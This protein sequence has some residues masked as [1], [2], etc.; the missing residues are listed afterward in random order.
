MKVK[1]RRAE[2]EPAL[3]GTLSLDSV[4]VAAES[5]GICGLPDDAI[6]ELAED[7][8]YRLRQVVQD[9]CKFKAHGKRKKLLPIDFDNAL[10]M[11]NME[12]LYGVQS[13]EH[14]PF[15][16]TSGG[17]RELSFQDERDVEL[18]ELVSAQMPKAPL[19]TTIRVHWLCIDGVQPAIPE[20]PPPVALEH[21][22]QESTN[23][24]S[25]IGK[26]PA[27]SPASALPTKS[28]P[29]RAKTIETVSVKQLAQHE[30]S[31][32]LQLYY[33]EITEACVGSDESRRAEAL[34]SLSS[35]PGLHQMLPRLCNFIF[36]GVKVN[37][38]QY[39]LALLIYLMRMVKALLDNQTLYL[40]KYLH[41]LIPSVASCILSRQLCARPEADNHWALRDFASRLLAQ[42]CKNFNT[43][44]NNM[45]TR[46][47][48]LFTGCLRG[49][50][51]SLAATYG[52]LAGLS[53]LGPEVIKSF[54]LPQVKPL[55]SRLERLAEQPVVS[56]ADRLATTH[57][58]Q[59]F[60]RG[61]TPLLKQLRSS[62]DVVEQYQA[63]YGYLGPMLCAAVS[64]ARSQT[65]AP[66]TAVSA[67]LGASKVA[68]G[69]AAAAAASAQA[70]PRLGTPQRTII[71]SGSPAAAGGSGR[72]VVLGGPR[73][74]APTQDEPSS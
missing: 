36:E 74:A 10:R 48:R 50:R 9:A 44:T 38:V 46:V 59:L 54:V 27:A 49:E 20:N 12:P 56:P 69:A 73:A 29:Q 2:Q 5:V 51:S 3:A 41:E 4:R 64:K 42:I 63:E 61:L 32:E 7:T 53:E 34:Q 45:Q 22:K 1:Q 43:S 35:D 23:P 33:K 31:V 47:T 55:G 57:L 37:V 16:F 39:N 58:K 40:E 28:G 66:Q 17:G 25:R 26:P 15:R 14:V 11:R 62:P 60:A 21:Q 30:L 19:E 24:A 68:V 67:S 72:L 8:T 52:A 18:G 6:R 13:L 70:A 65:A 71:V